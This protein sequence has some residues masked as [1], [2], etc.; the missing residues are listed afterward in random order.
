MH[1]PI[2]EAPAHLSVEQALALLPTATRILV[3]VEAPADTALPL[4]GTAVK[5]PPYARH[6]PGETMPLPSD[7]SAWPALLGSRVRFTGPLVPRPLALQGVVKR[8][9]SDDEVKSER[10]LAPTRD[11]AGTLWVLSATRAGEGGA[12]A[13]LAKGAYE[14]TLTRFADLTDNTASWT[15]AFSLDQVRAEAVKAGGAVADDALLLVEG[16][17]APKATRF[18]LPVK[19]AGGALLVRPFEDGAP[20][21]GWAQTGPLTG[22][23]WAW[24][25]EPDKRASLEAVLGAKLPARYGVIHVDDDAAE[26]NRKTTRGLYVFEGL[27]GALLLFSAVG[28]VRARR[29]R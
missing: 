9:L 13:W 5:R 18:A 7:A 6:R 21:P 3:T 29:R 26:L 15:L 14:G 20:L 25:V 16:D 17:E 12:D 19:G 1:P 10:L 28:F 24:D 27:G 22:V 23:L 11:S 4:Y 8:A 2:P